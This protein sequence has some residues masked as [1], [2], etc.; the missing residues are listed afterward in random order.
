M[1]EL[2][3]AFGVAFLAGSPHAKPKAVPAPQGS[4]AA[5]ALAGAGGVYLEIKSN[6]WWVGRGDEGNRLGQD[7]SVAG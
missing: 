3:S 2:L 1:S 4:C 5:C 7:A 6:I